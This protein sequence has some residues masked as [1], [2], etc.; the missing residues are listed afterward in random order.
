VHATD[1][2][3]RAAA[4]S[5]L[6]SSLLQMLLGGLAA[7]AARQAL[8]A[9]GDGGPEAQLCACRLAVLRALPGTL[10]ERR[11]EGRGW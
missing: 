6:A 9:T 10:C 11:E 1:A 8:P 2:A 3:A 5:S 7:Q 4:A